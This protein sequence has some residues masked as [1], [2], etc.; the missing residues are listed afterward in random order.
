MHTSRTQAQFA[1]SC[2]TNYT[3]AWHMTIA[4]K[5]LHPRNWKS[6]IW[7]SVD[8]F[9]CLQQSFNDQLWLIQRDQ[10]LLLETYV[11]IARS[12]MVPMGHLQRSDL[13]SNRGYTNS[14]R[15]GA[16]V[17]QSW[18]N[19]VID[20]SKSLVL[21]APEVQ[22]QYPCNWWGRHLEH[23]LPPGAPRD[24]IPKRDTYIHVYIY[25][26]TYASSDSTATLHDYLPRTKALGKNSAM[27]SVSSGLSVLWSSSQCSHLYKQVKGTTQ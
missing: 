10:A 3:L 22:S 7:L 20:L 13:C 14:N 6:T 17:S 27:I 4:T 26:Y 9:R 15:V 21:H 1:L 8:R 11:H 25:I 24:Y 5:T 23:V 18:L 19:E 2:S 12:A 16:V